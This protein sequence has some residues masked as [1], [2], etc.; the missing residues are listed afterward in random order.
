VSGS[1]EKLRRRGGNFARSDWSR[2]ARIAQLISPWNEYM[3]IS[4]KGNLLF[5]PLNV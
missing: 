4:G 3:V 1:L 2:E 5:S